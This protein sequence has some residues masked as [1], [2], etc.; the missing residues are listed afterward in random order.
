MN[1]DGRCG[2]PREAGNPFAY[3]INDN[4]NDDDDDFDMNVIYGNDSPDGKGKT[5]GNALDAL[6]DRDECQEQ[7]KEKIEG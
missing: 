6:N 2:S 4:V 5:G 3:G 1:R 7:M